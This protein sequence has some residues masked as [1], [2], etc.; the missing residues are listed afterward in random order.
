MCKA[1][2][3]CEKNGK[4]L[5]MPHTQFIPISTH[6]KL[7]CQFKLVPKNKAP[8]Y[9]FRSSLRALRLKDKP[10][11]SCNIAHS[12]WNLFIFILFLCFRSFQFIWHIR[13][14]RCYSTVPK[15]S[16]L[17]SVDCKRVVHIKHLK[18]FYVFIFSVRYCMR[19]LVHTVLIYFLY[20]ESMRI[21]EYRTPIGVQWLVLVI[22]FGIAN[23]YHS[24]WWC[25]GA[26]RVEIVRY[27][28]YGNVNKFWALS[29][30]AYKISLSEPLQI[31][32]LYI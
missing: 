18:V 4:N 26:V 10:S 22:P 30:S 2:N 29:N 17:I 25:C 27:C 24:C 16:A 5:A 23:G 9:I 8:P 11:W 14:F 21:H 19:H 15:F 3:C 31:E 13:R 7:Y 32:C 12:V 20:F 28:W 6:I 1:E